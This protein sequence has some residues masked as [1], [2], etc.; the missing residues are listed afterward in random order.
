MSATKNVKWAIKT[1]DNTCSTPA[2]AGGRVFVGSV[3]DGQG[4]LL[5]LE[6]G[7]GKLLW[8]WQAPVRTDIARESTSRPQGMVRRLP[9]SGGSAGRRRSTAIGSTW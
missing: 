7:A 3:R 2:I 1:G 9:A 5:C 4:V 8:R 6:E